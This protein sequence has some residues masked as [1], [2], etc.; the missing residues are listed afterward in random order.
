M[1]KFVQYGAGNIGRG[2]IGQLFSQSGYEVVFI[3]INQAL[4]DKLNKDKCYP[5]RVVSNNSSNEIIVDNVRAVSGLDI[6]KVAHEIATADIMATSVGVNILPKIIATLTAGLRKRWALSSSFSPA[7]SPVASSSAAE[8]TDATAAS[9]S[10]AAAATASDYAP[11]PLDILLCENLHNAG[12]HV[13]NMFKSELSEQ[14]ILIFDKTIGL[15]EASIGR[16]VPV[17]TPEMQG[18]NILRVVVEEY[19]ELPVDLSAFKGP[20]P[21]VANLLPFSPFSYYVDRKLYVHNMGHAIAAYL[22]KTKNYTYIWESISDQEIHKICKGAMMESAS[23]LSAEYGIKIENIIEHVEDLINRFGNRQ[24]GDTVERVGRDTK[25]KLS[26]EDRL[27][28]AANLCIRHGIY[29]D[30]IYKGIHAALLFENNDPGTIEINKIIKE[31]GIKSVLKD[32]CGLNPNSEL[33]KALLKEN[34]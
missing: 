17:M 5:I 4:V 32:I 12:L 16:M 7:V 6:E 25:R 31:N 15:V 30:N 1:L 26:P 29:P 22:G 14:E 24:L 3:D 2:F 8:A 33:F 19:C 21:K 9:S 10:T 18:D 27:I 23:A 34:L 28:G 11:R 20:L 13:R